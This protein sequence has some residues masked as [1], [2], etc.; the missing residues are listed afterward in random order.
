MDQLYTKKKVSGTCRCVD[1]REIWVWSVMKPGFS[2][3]L[4]SLVARIPMKCEGSHFFKI[5]VFLKAWGTKQDWWLGAHPRGCRHA[6]RW[7]GVCSTAPWGYDWVVLPNIH[8]T[9]NRMA[10][11]RVM[12]MLLSQ[13]LSTH[14]ISRYYGIYQNV[15]NKPPHLT[16]AAVFPY[17]WW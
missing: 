13:K 11:M 9:P 4:V 3:L 14:H 6:H 2:R 15:P 12:L 17:G 10:M 8:K 1:Q 7:P 16:V 5:W